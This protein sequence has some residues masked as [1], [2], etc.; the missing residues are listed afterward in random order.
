[1]SRCHRVLKWRQL[2]GRKRTVVFAAN[3]AWNILNFRMNLIRALSAE[4]LNPIALVPPG[5]GE[6]DF[7]LRECR[8]TSCPCQLTTRL[9]VGV[10]WSSATSRRSERFGSGL[11]RIYPQA[12]YLRFDGR[13]PR[14]G[15]P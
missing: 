15:I 13:C 12:E 9:F 5:E 6:A 4:G 8:C 14:S 2:R 3:S 1:L 7:V 11:P 10:V